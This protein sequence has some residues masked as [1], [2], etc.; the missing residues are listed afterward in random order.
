MRDR[1]RAPDTGCVLP[2]SFRG[3]RIRTTLAVL[4]A[5]A[6][7]PDQRARITADVQDG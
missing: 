1:G 3:V 6:L 2:P 4:P 7:S 5:A